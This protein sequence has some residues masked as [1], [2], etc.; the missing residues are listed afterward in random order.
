VKPPK[1][2]APPVMGLLWFAAGWLT[3]RAAGLPP[4]VPRP[5]NDL[6]WVLVVLGLRV[7]IV[8][9]I[10]FRK[11]GT[12]EKPWETPSTLVVE[13][14]YRR[15]RNPM[16]LGMATALFGVA[17]LLR[18]LEMFVVPFLFIAT[19]NMTWVPY[20]EWVLSSRF[21]AAYDDYRARV[22]RWL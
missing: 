14:L 8:S 18:T 15:T 6:G 2:L 12:T 10:R 13:G 17:V 11:A 21:G 16:Y 7:P 19:L 3:R 4:V 1:L 20:E 22:R 5:W 9:V